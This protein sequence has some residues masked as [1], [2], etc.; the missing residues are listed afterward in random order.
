MV[1]SG[2][3]RQL[4]SVSWEVRYGSPFRDEDGS[5]LENLMN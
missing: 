2:R 4:L 1:E 5:G 3:R